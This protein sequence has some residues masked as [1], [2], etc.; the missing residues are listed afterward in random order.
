[1]PAE[2]T[3]TE[4]R[5]LHEI[6]AEMATDWA[7]K[8]SGIYFGAVPY[9]QALQTMSWMTDKFGED[10]AYTVVMYLLSNAKYYRGPVAKRIKAELN[11]RLKSQR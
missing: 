8:P 11:A 10:D 3:T 6:G 2:T 9:L 5:P 4:P 7:A 1:M